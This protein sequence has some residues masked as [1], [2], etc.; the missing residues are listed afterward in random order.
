MPEVI[1]A[2][3]VDNADVVEVKPEV[4]VS[5]EVAVT[6]AKEVAGRMKESKRSGPEDRWSLLEHTHPCKTRRPAVY[7]ILRAVYVSTALQ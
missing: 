1:V 4:V 5:T 7:L 3:V 6:W 2:K